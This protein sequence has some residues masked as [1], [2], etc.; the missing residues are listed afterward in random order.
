MNKLKRRHYKKPAFLFVMG[1]M[2]SRSSLLN[3]ILISNPEIVGLGESNAMYTGTIKLLYM[4]I[5]TLLKQKVFFFK[6]F[7]YTDQINHN[8]KTP[9]AKI[10][11]KKSLKIIIL[12]RSPDATIR[13]LLKLTKDFYKP[14]DV[15]KATD[16]YKNRIQYLI[17]LKESLPPNRYMILNSE[18]LVENTESTLSEISRF[19]QLSTPLRSKYELF[20]F[21][22]I[23]GDPD[24]N[25][26]K[27]TVI[28]NMEKPK[29][30]TSKYNE[31]YS[32]FRKL[33]D[34]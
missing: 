24:K 13:S 8:S 21:T 9:N 1:H 5:K 12:V 10:L 11:L 30:S 6:S 20:D 3:H 31:E 18:D 14:W 15:K 19:L 22:G 33:I 2:R 17:E 25:I 34:Q 28:K 32:L 27:G 26:K 23:H 16:Y 4:K 29:K 7:I